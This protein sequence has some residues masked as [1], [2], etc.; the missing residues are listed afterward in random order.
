MST[1]NF[2][3]VFRVALWNTYNNRCFYCKQP[4]DWNQYQIDHLVPEWLQGNPEKLKQ[5]INDY[6]LDSD[7]NLNIAYNL[8]P[9]HTQCNKSKGGQLFE[10]PTMLFYIQLSKARQD[11]LNKQIKLAKSKKNKDAVFT[12]VHTALA[13][14]LIDI[15]EMVKLIET[16]KENQWSSHPIQ[17][18]DEI[19]YIDGVIQTFY[20][21]GDYS[22]LAE[23]HISGNEIDMIN[24]EG[25]NTIPGT[26]K[27]F[28]QA[29]KDGFYPK[30]NLDIKGASGFTFL[31][32]LLNMLKGATMSKI[33]YIDEPRLNLNDLA[34]LSPNI[35][36]DIDNELNEH[37]Q[38]GHSIQ[39]LVDIGL[40]K[41]HPPHQYEISLEYNSFEV[42]LREQFR[43]DFNGDGIEDIFVQTWTNATGGTLGFGGTTVLTRYSNK[44]LIEPA[45]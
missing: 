4:L 30:T 28:E 22:W 26:L 45:K 39:D 29:I 24:D 25:I 41:V 1:T 16:A 17:L 27:E 11:T 6:G 34:Y 15:K 33:S 18:N 12:K 9:A 38:K 20:L 42:S 36:F 44:H 43:A 2:D 40:V 19:D 10:K 37:I 3:D 23:K 5:T 35:L 32:N 7:F 8:V 13:T 31:E 21:G 14:G